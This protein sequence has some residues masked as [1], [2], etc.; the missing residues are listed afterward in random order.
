[1]ATVV[2]TA[3]VDITDKRGNVM[4]EYIMSLL[5]RLAGGHGGSVGHSSHTR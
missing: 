5:S 1:M 3:A 2:T 4:F